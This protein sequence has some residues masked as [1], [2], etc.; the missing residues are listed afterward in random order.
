MK[1]LLVDET[2]VSLLVLLFSYAGVSKLLEKEKF[3]FQMSLSPVSVMKTAAPVLGWILP[4]LEIVLVILLLIGPTRRAGLYLSAILL[5]LFEIYISAMLLS[6]FDLP[7]TCGGIISG[8][9]WKN[10]LLFNAFFLTI[11]VFCLCTQHPD[12]KGKQRTTD[13]AF[14]SRAK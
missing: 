3:V 6:G 5:S 13:P 10:H 12:R 2:L 11:S 9:S 8:L 14:I 4:V 1:K 7:C